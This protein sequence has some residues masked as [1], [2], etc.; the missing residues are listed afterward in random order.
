MRDDWKNPAHKQSRDCAL[1]RK[2]ADHDA[3]REDRVDLYRI[4][5]E[6]TGTFHSVWRLASELHSSRHRDSGPS[7]RPPLSCRRPRAVTSTRLLNSILVTSMQDAR[8]ES[9]T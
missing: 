2:S 9:D 4:M 1:R 5:A 8:D 6:S 3:E 7:S